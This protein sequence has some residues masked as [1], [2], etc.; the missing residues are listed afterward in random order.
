MNGAKK[1]RVWIR[2]KPGFYAQ[3]D[4]KVD[5][6]AGDEEEAVSEALRR[7]RTGAFRD[8]DDS[9]WT[10]EKVERLWSVS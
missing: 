7:L 9:M 4:G 8:R 2:S 10:V 6:F 3:Y 1:F 5:V